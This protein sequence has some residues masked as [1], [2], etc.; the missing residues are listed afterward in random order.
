MNKYLEETILNNYDNEVLSLY[1]KSLLNK[2]YTTIRTNNLKASIEEIKEVFN[3][4]NIEYK[5]IPWYPNAYIILNKD[6]SDLSKLSIYEEGK[7]YLQS[8][9]SQIPPLFLEPL[10][11]ELILDMAASPG[12]K[13]SELCAL[14]NNTC[15]I[16]AIEKNKI[17]Y[18]RLK[19]NLDKLGT[20]KVNVLNIDSRNL[21]EYFMFD[22]ILLDAPCSGS[23]TLNKETINTFTE[24]LFERSIK[25]QYELLNTA[26]KHLRVNGILIYSTCSIL[27]SENEDIIKRILKENDNIVLEPITPFNNLPILSNKLEGTITLYPNE[28]YE[29]FF[30][31]KLKRIK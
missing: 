23:G 28:Y 5:E 16:T 31:A 13:T 20:K 9:S 10:P 27:S 4:N 22:K 25:T 1:N 29:G 19:Y 17:R 18:E 8:L 24:E 21:D 6:E 12:G 14:S 3:K 30:I 7:I 26:I 15:L 11:N 2:R